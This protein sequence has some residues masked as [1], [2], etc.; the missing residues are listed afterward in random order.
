MKNITIFVGL[1]SGVVLAAAGQRGNVAIAEGLQVNGIAIP[2][3]GAKIWP[4]A[5]GDVVK[6]SAVPLLLKLKDG[7]K[8]VLGQNSEAKLES[9]NGKES[10]RLVNGSMQYTLSA[11]SKMQLVANNEPLSVRPGSTGNV[12]AVTTTI[13]EPKAVTTLALPPLSRRK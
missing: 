1:I 5:D 10:V 4:V 6:S 13:V 9:A 3:S 7:S 11:E 8:I 2:Q 12:G